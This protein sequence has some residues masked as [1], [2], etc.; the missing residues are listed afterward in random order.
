[1]GD[2]VVF[3]YEKRNYELTKEHFELDRTV[4]NVRSD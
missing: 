4:D 3:F 2:K 1:M